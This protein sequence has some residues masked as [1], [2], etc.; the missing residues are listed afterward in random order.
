MNRVPRPL[1]ATAILILILTGP[2]TAKAQQEPQRYRVALLG[3]A[4]ERPSV[5]AFTDGL[6]ELGYVEGKNL[7][8]AIRS[9]DGRP[10]RL[11]QLASELVA[12]K[13][14]VLVVASTAPTLAAKRATTSIPIVFVSVI[15]PVGA[16][17]VASLARPGGNVSGVTGWIGGAGFA[18]KWV[19]LLKEAVPHLAHVVALSNSANPQSRPQVHDVQEAAQALKMKLDVVDAGNAAGLDK[20]FAAIAASAARGMVVTGDPFFTASRA[21]IIGF[22]ASKRLPAVYFNKRFADDGGLV[23]YGARL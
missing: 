19:E 2:L 20:A 21:R 5:A 8:L 7:Y 17:I 1:L 23:A 18:G 9:A 3:L 12:L 13:V 4:T 11:P 10:E 16:G 6:R 14:D 22:A 15:D